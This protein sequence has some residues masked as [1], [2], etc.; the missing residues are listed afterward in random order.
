ML[1][2]Y[3]IIFT[4]LQQEL[5]THLIFQIEASELRGQST[6]SYESFGDSP[7]SDRYPPLTGQSPF[8]HH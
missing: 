1:P 5:G 7:L 3:T 4:F 2:N 6:L 8:P